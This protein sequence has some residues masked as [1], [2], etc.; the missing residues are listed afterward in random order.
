MDML[1]MYQKYAQ[2]NNWTF[3]TLSINTSDIDGL[4]DATALI[5][6]DSVF[7]KLKYEVGVHRVQRI[8]ETEKL[9]RVH[10]STMTVAVLPE[11]EDVDIE[12]N[13]QDIRI[14]TKRASGAGGQH[15]NT[16]D[17]AIRLTHIP[18]GIVVNIQD[19]RSQHK[20]KDKAFKILKAK[21][22]E[23]ER[24][25][26]KQER[27]MNRKSQVGT[28]DRSERIRTY[29]FPQDRVTDHRIGLTL[30]GIDNMMEGDYL[31]QIIDSLK[32]HE[33]EL[34]IKDLLSKGK[35]K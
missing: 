6:G 24:N 10:T 12:I 26:L 32:Q 19:E 15:V 25:K 8:P 9:N 30:H 22:Y 18:T 11:A 28:G 27:D 17:S 5:K 2:L 1:K 4:K 35:N 20:N 14:D 31:D 29:N 34:F 13:P 7:G 16:T 21:L 3:E 33:R 23:L